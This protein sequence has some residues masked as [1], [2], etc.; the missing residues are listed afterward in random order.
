MKFTGTEANLNTALNDLI[1]T[2]LITTTMLA[3]KLSLFKSTT[4][5]TTGPRYLPPPPPSPLRLLLSTIPH[6]SS[7]PTPILSPTNTILVLSSANTNGI[8]I[9]DDASESNKVIQVTLTAA[10]GI[11][12]LASTDGL[13][14]NGL[15]G[16][17][18]FIMAGTMDKISTALDGLQYLP[19]PGANGFGFN[20][21]DTITV[22]VQDL[23]S[24]GT[25]GFL[26][27]TNSLAVT[28]NVIND[29]PVHLFN[30]SSISVAQTTNEDTPLS[31]SG[32][33]GNAITVTD[34]SDEGDTIV[35][36]SLSV[37]S[38]SLTLSSTENLTFTTGD[39]ETDGNMTFSGKLTDINTALEG[40]L[41]APAADSSATATLTI[42]TDD[43]GNNGTGDALTDTD[44]VVINVTAINDAPN[45]TFAN[46]APAI[47]EDLPLLFNADANTLITLSDDASEDGSQI[48]LKF[49]VTAG[50]LTLPLD[51]DALTNNNIG[52][53]A[54]AN[55]SSNMTL[56]GAVD[57]LSLVLDGLQYNAPPDFVGTVTLTL[58]ADDLGNY[59]EGDALQVTS[60]ATINVSAVNDAPVLELPGDSFVNE[61]NSL[62]F[63]SANNNAIVVSDPDTY[64]DS[65]AI[66][67]TMKLVDDSDAEVSDR[68]TFSLGSNSDN[69]Y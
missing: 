9:T 27:A 66:Q 32:A 60:T 61:D 3:R 54:G 20:G 5:A 55:N 7:F 50:T 26:E 22:F 57:K 6:P 35:Q 65:S 46:N 41:F 34:D 59:G 45:L 43:Q 11:L 48:S 49:S 18:S 67:A 36:V 24:T 17:A 2:P 15:N 1:Y 38:G 31:F 14:F 53:I 12:T 4:K 13:T 39:G 28:V 52:I 68:G 44:S 47:S 58:I 56:T 37:D 42:V 25:G 33:N 63:S 8:S 23:G 40:L 19:G 21:T 62:T 30:D 16:S 29:A 64:S 10:N 51:A 69:L